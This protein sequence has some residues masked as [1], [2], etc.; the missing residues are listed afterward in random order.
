MPLRQAESRQRIPLLLL[1]TGYFALAI[2]Y[3]IVTP[4]FE[5]PDEHHHYFTIQTLV[6]SGQLPIA[7]PDTLARQE[8][9]QPPL[10][11][12]LGSTFLTPFGKESG[13]PTLWANPY[14]QFNAAP[15]PQNNNAF[16][17]VAECGPGAFENRTP[18]II[19][20]FQYILIL[21]QIGFSQFICSIFDSNVIVFVR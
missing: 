6:E 11:Y 4:L 13:T 17:H 9:A 12:L 7:S 15:H 2:S 20:S 18:F 10:Y 14:I 3:N 21:Y 16:I 1:L 5:A 19:I 8:A